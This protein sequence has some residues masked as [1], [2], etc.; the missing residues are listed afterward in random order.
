MTDTVTVYSRRDSVMSLAREHHL[1]S[2]DAVYLNL[3]LRTNAKLATIE[4]A[5]VWRF[6][7]DNFVLTDLRER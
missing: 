1:T 3:V 6:I 2:Y 7:E 4:D 5:V